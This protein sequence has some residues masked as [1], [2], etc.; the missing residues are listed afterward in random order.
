MHERHLTL[1]TPHYQ[2]FSKQN[3]SVF[4]NVNNTVMGRYWTPQV[5]LN[6]GPEQITQDKIMKL[7]FIIKITSEWKLQ[8]LH[9]VTRSTTTNNAMW[10]D[11]NFRRW[12]PNNIIRHVLY[13]QT[14]CLGL[15]SKMCTTQMNTSDD[16]E[17][18]DIQLISWL[19]SELTR[20]LC[21]C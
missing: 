17:L 18:W 2:M 16:P 20:Q 3:T 8:Y 10:K 13:S 15:H 6:R 5:L 14:R 9:N 21:P 1:H 12:I 19:F 4:R 7:K 11:E